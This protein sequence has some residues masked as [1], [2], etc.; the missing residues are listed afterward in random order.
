MMLNAKK[1]HDNDI[2]CCKEVPGVFCLVDLN[3]HTVNVYLNLMVW[4]ILTLWIR[5]N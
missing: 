4:V 5:H 3:N 2:H 1:E